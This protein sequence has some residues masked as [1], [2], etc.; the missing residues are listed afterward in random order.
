VQR[1]NLSDFRPTSKID[2]IK[3]TGHPLLLGRSTDYKLRVLNNFYDGTVKLPGRNLHPLNTWMT[4]HDPTVADLERLVGTVRDAQIQEI[5]IAV[6]FLP[7]CQMSL[8]QLAPLYLWLRHSLC[9]QTHRNMLAPRR[10]QY[11]ERSHDYVRLRSFTPLLGNGTF[12]WTS[13]DAYSAVRLYI[14]QTHEDKH[15]K[16]VLR[17]PFV[18]L[19]ATLTAGA[20]QHAHAWKVGSLSVFAKRL[21][22]FVSPLFS[23]GQAVKPAYK[24]RVDRLRTS[25]AKIRAEALL[26]RENTKLVRAWTR[27][28]SVYAAKHG[29]KVVPDRTAN[30]LI[31]TA[32]K[33]LGERLTRLGE[34]EKVADAEA[35]HKREAEW[36]S[37]MSGPLP[38]SYR[39]NN[40]S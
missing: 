30:R 12:T 16:T 40:D 10:S 31:E 21:R 20:M 34:P 14:K 29:L 25:T 28:G 13:A 4:I 36:R 15:G 3:V 35:W 11:S 38:R 39:G 27:Y 8:T 19:E 26:L 24:I 9:P 17:Q 2:F 7:R 32:L 5:E 6:D 33:R 23:V 37:E 18:R 1:P 22:W